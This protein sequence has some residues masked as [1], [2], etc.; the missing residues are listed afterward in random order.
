VWPFFRWKPAAFNLFAL[1]IGAM[2][3]DLECPFVY[4]V[5]WNKWKARS[6]MHSL[7]G[8]ATVDIV[9]TVL[10]V[11]YFVPWFLKYLDGN[12]RDKRYFVFAGTDLRAHRTGIG[13]IVGSTLIGTYSHVLIDVLHH[14]YNPLTFPFSQYYDFNLVLFNDLTISGIIMQGGA[15][16]LLVLMIYFWYFK[17]IRA[18]RARKPGAEHSPGKLIGGGGK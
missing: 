5:V 6:V 15:L 9:L 10:L 18:G 8:A 17:D 4:L 16:L 2:I 1:T 12:V 7:L 13:A 14:P 3:P 11:L